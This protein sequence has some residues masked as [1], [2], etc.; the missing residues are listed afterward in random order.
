M[1]WNSSTY[2]KGST[3][4][5]VFVINY[6]NMLPALF[7]EPQYFYAFKFITTLKFNDDA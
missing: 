1:A 5:I 6:E 7:D 2:K 3:F 4:S